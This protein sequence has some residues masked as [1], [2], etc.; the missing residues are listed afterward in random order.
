MPEKKSGMYRS[1][2]HEVRCS[3]VPEPANLIGEAQ[4]ITT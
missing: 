1:Q 4:L 3:A 2:T